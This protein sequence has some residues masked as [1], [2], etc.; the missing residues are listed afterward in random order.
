MKYH[1]HIYVNNR[2]II[3]SAKKDFVGYSSQQVAKDKA[4]SV[5]LEKK[6]SNYT[7]TIEPSNIY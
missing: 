5:I 6:Y 7:I 4:N 1:Y 2:L 3:T